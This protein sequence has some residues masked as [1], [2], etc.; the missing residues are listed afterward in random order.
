MDEFF[1]KGDPKVVSEGLSLSALFDVACKHDCL[2]GKKE[3][4]ESRQSVDKHQN[5][6]SAPLHKLI[7]NFPP[8]SSYQ[9]SNYKIM[10]NIQPEGGTYDDQ[11][12]KTLVHHTD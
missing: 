6:D 9:V 12:M 1:L 2:W 10:Q 11:P 8:F 7:T 5:W 4:E 3:G